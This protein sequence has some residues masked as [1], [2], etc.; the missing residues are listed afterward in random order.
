MDCRN[1]E[2][3]LQATIL[4]P[5][6]SYP[7]LIILMKSSLLV[8]RRF[9][10]S[11]CDLRDLGWNQGFGLAIH[12]VPASELPPLIFGLS[13]PF[14]PRYPVPFLN[15]LYISLIFPN[16]INPGIIRACSHVRFHYSSFWL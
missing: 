6:V 10:F 4:S 14:M 1:L 7:N 8:L 5:P 12:F 9:P 2:S 13:P 16:G 15:L 3:S 11:I